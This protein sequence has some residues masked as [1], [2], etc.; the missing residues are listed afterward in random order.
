MDE[1]TQKVVDGTAWR[2]F[3]DMLADAGEVILA[4]GNPDSP[5]DR[6]EGFRMLT[7]LLRGAL[8]SK[9][10]HGRATEPVLVVHVPRDDQDR[11]REPRQP[12]PRRVARRAVRLPDLGHPRRREVDQLQPVLRRRL[13]RR[14]A[15]HRRDDARGADAHRAR[16]HVRADHLAARTPGELAA[17]PRPTPAASRSARRSS[18]GRTN[19][20]PS[21][22]S[23]GIGA[24]ATS[25]RTADGRG[26]V[27]VAALRRLLREGRRRD[28]RRLGDAAGAVAE[29]VHRRGRVTRD[30]QVQG[31]AD[32]VAPG[33]LRSRRR[34]GAR[35]SR[36]RRRRAS[37]G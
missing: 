34:R 31:P 3:C 18:T 28:R 37:T 35:S 36:S 19:G 24:D 30:R 14:R 12:L 29:R 7:R 32:Q 23:S 11:R 9:L 33:L 21:C 15:G 5:L 16:R 2:E 6:A 1:I 13:R 20:T 8:E 17:S 26:A 22:T 4:E 27:P 10:E 25:A